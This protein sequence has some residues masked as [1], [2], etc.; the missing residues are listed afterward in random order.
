MLQE[1]LKSATPC[2][3][4]ELDRE[5]CS[6][7]QEGKLRK[8]EIRGKPEDEKWNAMYRILFPFD[9]NIPLPCRAS[10]EVLMTS[11]R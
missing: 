1:H 7:E 3:V 10:Q 9:E 11:H 8:K 4:R 5:G 6:K 2:Q